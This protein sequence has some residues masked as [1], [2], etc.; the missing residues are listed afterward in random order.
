MVGESPAPNVNRLAGVMARN[1]WVC[2]DDVV[3][4]GTADAD[5]REAIESP[6]VNGSASRRVQQ[7][8]GGLARARVLNRVCHLAP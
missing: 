3:L 4:V 2:D 8:K 1:G 7:M 6:A 5:Q